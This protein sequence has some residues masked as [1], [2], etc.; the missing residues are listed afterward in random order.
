MSYGKDAGKGNTHVKK[1][2]K[3][4]ATTVIPNTTQRAPKTGSDNRGRASSRNIQKQEGT[5]ASTP[6]DRHRQPEFAEEPLNVGVEATEEQR[7]QE[8]GG[9]GGGV[10]S[11][12]QY[13]N[14]LSSPPFVTS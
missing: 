6:E 5:E 8:I 3:A 14:F 2:T 1:K 7:H 12:S 10:S 4:T 13:S 9:Q 11:R